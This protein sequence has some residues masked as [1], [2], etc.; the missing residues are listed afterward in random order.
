MKWEPCEVCGT[1]DWDEDVANG[2][3]S[4]KNCGRSYDDPREM[5]QASGGFD[6]DTRA[7]P[8]ESGQFIWKNKEPYP[9][10][11]DI[12]MWMLLAEQKSDTK[13]ESKKVRKEIS[14]I[15]KGRGVESNKGWRYNSSSKWWA[16]ARSKLFFQSEVFRG[17]SDEAVIE[18]LSEELMLIEERDWR[19][20]LSHLVIRGSV[21]PERSLL[22]KDLQRMTTPSRER[23]GIEFFVALT[24]EEGGFWFLCDY[25]KILGL[26]LGMIDSL[27]K[28]H[29]PFSNVMIDRV[30]NIYSSRQITPR[31]VSSFAK[32]C[33][34]R[35]GIDPNGIEADSSLMLEEVDTGVWDLFGLGPIDS[36]TSE[37]PHFWVPYEESKR[38]ISFNGQDVSACKGGL[39][40]LKMPIVMSHIP[41]AYIVAQRLYDSWRLDDKWR[42][43]PKKILNWI[44]EDLRWCPADVGQIDKWWEGVIVRNRGDSSSSVTHLR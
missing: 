22:S 18:D 29:H 43:H 25:A 27:F 32:K 7:R 17:P 21:V 34:R 8:V 38:M 12:Q 39:R 14:N 33:A 3:L 37:P 13:S 44:E 28:G 41:L 20:D 6:E 26:N 40:P 24:E 19:A 2:F 30:R 9:L 23:I 35:L 11:D 31:E 15:K 10:P 5:M 36:E 4:C 16:D 1:N 42:N